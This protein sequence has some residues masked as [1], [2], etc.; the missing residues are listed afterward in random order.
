MSGEDNVRL[1]VGE[2]MEIGQKVL[3]GVENEVGKQRVSRR[4]NGQME[5]KENGAS[6]S[7]GWGTR[8][9][10]RKNGKAGNGG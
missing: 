8:R 9:R 7:G 2:V 10:F 6:G 1:E 4:L 3:R 5:G